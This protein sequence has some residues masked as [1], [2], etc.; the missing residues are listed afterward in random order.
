MRR[1][2]CTT[3]PPAR[4]GTAGPGA[5]NRGGE[6]D[7][8][9]TTVRAS[10]VSSSIWLRG[11]PSGASSTTE[12]WCEPGTRLRFPPT[13]ACAA[14]S[15]STSD[16]RAASETNP[17]RSLPR[18]LSRTARAVPPPAPPSRPPAEGGM[19]GLDP[20]A[21][22]RRDSLDLLPVRAWCALASDLFG[23]CLC[24]KKRQSIARVPLR[25]ASTE[26][27]R[28]DS[29]TRR[30]NRG[31]HS[32][33]NRV[34][35]I[36]HCS[37]GNICATSSPASLQSRA[38]NSLRQKLVG[39]AA[40]WAAPTWTR[41]GVCS[42]HTS[43]AASSSAKAPGASPAHASPPSSFFQVSSVSS[44]SGRRRRAVWV[45]GDRRVD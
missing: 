6:T 36:S 11:Y 25:A 33:T 24:F 40:R 31:L 16:A 13:R 7:F 39:A 32:C 9:D 15:F 12:S 14:F 45:P 2:W 43:G 17:P 27:R 21:V 3:A 42:L 18:E 5:R 1:S 41:Q 38:M 29:R 4:R 34:N 44:Q 8:H 28:N 22:P 23:G 30:R 35:N 19:G 37:S 20:K 26:K 10:P